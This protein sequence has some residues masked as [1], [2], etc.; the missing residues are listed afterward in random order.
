MDKPLLEPGVIYTKPEIAELILDIIG[1]TPDKKLWEFSLLDPSYGEGV[2]LEVAV[3]RLLLSLENHS[4]DIN[5]TNTLKH[6]SQSIKGFE[7]NDRRYTIGKINVTSILEH[8]LST[9]YIESIISHWF[10]KDDYLL[11]QKQDLQRFD[12]I[13]GNP[14]Y[15]RQELIEKNLLDIYRNNY[16]TMTGRA[17]LY[18]P[19]I[20]KS[21]E[22][23]KL[24]G[25]LG[26]ICADRFTRNQYG[27]EIR[28]YIYKFFNM[29]F[30][31]DLNEAK[32]FG[33]DVSAY[34]AVL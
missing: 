34:P 12:F 20:Q 30:Y 24:N 10:I 14:P 19:F 3:Q 32:V 8:T 4:V 5:N 23:L 25:Q 33:D 26:F 21:L 6:L 7:I 1:Y 16:S 29:R 2:F 11:Y 31:I 17:D 28:N 22:L 27:R 13:V 15:V 9:K 18:I